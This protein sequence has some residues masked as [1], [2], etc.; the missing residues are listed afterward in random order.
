MEEDVAEETCGDFMGLYP[1]VDNDKS[2]A[3]ST[4]IQQEEL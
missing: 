3:I 1:K 4:H 2:N